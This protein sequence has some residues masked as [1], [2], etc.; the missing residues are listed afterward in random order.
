LA[1][2]DKFKRWRFVGAEKQRCNNILLRN[3]KSQKLAKSCDQCTRQ[4]TIVIFYRYERSHNKTKP[5]ALT[6][7]YNKC[8]GS[9]WLALSKSSGWLRKR[10][11]DFFCVIF[12]QKVRYFE[13]REFLLCEV[14]L[15]VRVMA[16]KSCHILTKQIILVNVRYSMLL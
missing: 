7:D 1:L 11:C 14:Y 16:L 6:S 2:P 13:E 9:M 5:N 8:H 4:P 10:I 15:D 3:V 12:T